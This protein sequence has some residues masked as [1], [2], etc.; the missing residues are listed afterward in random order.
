MKKRLLL[1]SMICMA[2]SGQSFAQQLSDRLEG[3]LGAMGIGVADLDVSTKFYQDVLGLSVLRTYELGYI[4]EIVL[5]Y[6]GAGGAV[7]VL[8]NW[9]EQART[10]D[11][12]NVKLVFYIDDPAAAIERIRAAGGEILR[13]ASPIEALNGTV[14]GLG[15]DPDNYVVE[16]I[17]RAR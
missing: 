11:G 9:P 3:H 5:G 7:V 13:E 17:A 1:A 8:M 12:D 15:R 4:N 14:V 10:Y 6:A 16:V 2:L